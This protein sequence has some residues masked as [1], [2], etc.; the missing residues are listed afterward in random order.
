MHGESIG[1]AVTPT[2]A[3]AY[4]MVAAFLFGLS[5]YPAVVSASEPMPDEAL[6]SMP[7]E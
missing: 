5:R 2:V 3:V 1:I 7:A 6:A 4:A